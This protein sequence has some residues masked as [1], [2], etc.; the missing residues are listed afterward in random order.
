[1]LDVGHPEKVA[2][3]IDDEQGLHTVAEPMETLDG[4]EPGVEPRGS[5]GIDSLGV[6]R[7][8]IASQQERPRRDAPVLVSGQR[9][10]PQRLERGGNAI[11]ADRLEKV[12]DDQVFSQVLKTLQAIGEILVEEPA[13]SS[14]KGLNN[15]LDHP[16]LQ[17][18]ERHRALGPEA[19]MRSQPFDFEAH[20]IK[21]VGESIM[22][23][24]WASRPSR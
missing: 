21:I 17:R 12:G 18:Q 8:A 22:D 4:R 3:S 11:R 1:M 14:V 13:K 16:P 24:V 20:T 5:L 6:R 19:Q 23:L 10:H 9:G 7:V 15:N 2:L